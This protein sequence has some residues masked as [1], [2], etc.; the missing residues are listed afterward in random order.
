METKV[1]LFRGSGIR[2]MPHN[3]EWWFVIDDVVG[4]FRRRITE[5]T[6]AGND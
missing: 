1:A 3:N 6:R 4:T 5:R 2:K